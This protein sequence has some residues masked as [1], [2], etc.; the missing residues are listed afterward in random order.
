MK[1]FKIASPVSIRDGLEYF[2]FNTLVTKDP[3]SFVQ[4]PYMSFQ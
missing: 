2:Y 1:D 4:A 3:Q